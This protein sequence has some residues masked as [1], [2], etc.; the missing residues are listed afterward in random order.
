MDSLASARALTSSR[1]FYNLVL[2][3][4]CAWVAYRVLRYTLTKKQIDLVIGPKRKSWFADT[5]DMNELLD[6]NAWPAWEALR[7]QYGPVTKVNGFVGTQ[8]LHIYDPLALYHILVKDQDFYHENELFRTTFALA[9]GPGL[10][11][12][13]GDQHRKQRKLLTPAFSVAHI[14]ELIPVFYSVTY[15]LRHALVSQVEH[16]KT[17]IDLLS[18]ITRTA[19]EIIGQSGLGYS[20]DP[21]VEGEVAHPFA[22][23]V[24][25]F[26][27][28]LN[29]F[30]VSRFLVLPLVHKLGPPKF[31]RFIV[32]AV[33]WKRLHRLRDIID[34]IHNTCVGVF[35]S[36]KAAIER[37][38]PPIA[39]N[40][41]DGK[42]IISLL[43]KG[44]MAATESE[45]ITDEE[46]AAQLSTLVF[47]AMDTTSNTLA[48]T[49]ELL[50]QHKDVQERL[51]QEVTEARAEGGDLAYHELDTLPY[52]DAVCREVLRLHPVITFLLRTPTKDMTLPL[53]KP[54]TLA[55]GSITDHIL[56]S[57]GQDIMIGMMASNR[58]PELWGPDA[59][60]FKP[61][62][63]LSPLPQAV[64]D[65]PSA[66]VYSHLLTFIGG[67][68]GC[69]GFK[70][71]I[72]EMKVILSVLLES[73]KF[74]LTDK[75]VV[76]EI[77]GV[78]QPCVK[79]PSSDK[80]VI[81]F[82]MNVSLV[83]SKN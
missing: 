23:A 1:V 56:V 81:S 83:P 18:W 79:D 22:A 25:D 39:G 27:Q 74:E 51:R 48:R 78:V 41:W 67:Q 30:T 71:A 80:T 52:L 2:P 31:R 16:G 64:Q 73:L 50:S 72:L 66:G 75:K 24:R 61:E 3:V 35:E 20:F 19:L 60:E 68:R 46:I 38:E 7:K 6:P 14:R 82:P 26:A 10:L 13:L 15:K 53:H 21:L 33:P 9:F 37:G 4:S 77:N 43:L 62:R 54:V 40:P 76:W 12:S 57:K 36:K 34:T 45:R 63:W 29:T 49:L 42:D 28:V 65:A 17:E 55:D 5:G 47:A 58:N 11:S 69:I 44:N 59:D 8:F 32:D 70:F